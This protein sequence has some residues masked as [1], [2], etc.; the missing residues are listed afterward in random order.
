MAL[1]GQW[2]R[3]LILLL[4]VLLL[5]MHLALHGAYEL[6]LHG[7]LLLQVGHH[8]AVR[9]CARVWQGGRKRSVLELERTT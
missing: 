8:R 4:L 6:L 7:R 3:L 2:A 5:G 9:A 1:G